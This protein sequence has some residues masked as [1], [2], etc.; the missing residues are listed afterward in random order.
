MTRPATLFTH[1]DCADTSLGTLLLHAGV[2]HPEDLLFDELRFRLNPSPGIADGL[3]LTFRGDLPIEAMNRHF[4]LRLVEHLAAGQADLERWLSDSTVPEGSFA[5]VT[6]DQYEYESSSFHHTAHVPHHLLVRGAGRAGFTVLDAYPHSPFSGV[7]DRRRFARWTNSP[8]LGAQ[9]FYGFR[10]TG[11]AADRTRSPLAGCWRERVR[12]NA[13]AMLSTPGEGVEALHTL[14]GHLDAWIATG[15]WKAVAHRRE[16]PVSSFVEVGALRRGHAMWL[17]R[18]ASFGPR[19]LTTCAD[20][21]LTL[22]RQWD[23]LAHVWLTAPAPTGDAPGLLVQVPRILRL[24][25]GT[26]RR[27][28]ERICTAARIT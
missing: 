17:R 11:A 5:A 13:E 19:E 1:G 23:T 7:V 16:L 9:R 3:R 6:V 8:H 14:A 15:A 27:T 25:A 4:G 12:S 10:V 26:E 24:L 22:A 20:A 28:V 21:V 2:A 18:A